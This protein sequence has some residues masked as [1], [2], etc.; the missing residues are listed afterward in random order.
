MYL[1]TLKPCLGDAVGW[2]KGGSTSALRRGA[3]GPTSGKR[4][5]NGSKTFQK[6]KIHKSQVGAAIQQKHLQSNQ[7]SMYFLPTWKMARF[8]GSSLGWHVRVKAPGSSPVGTGP[9]WLLEVHEVYDSSFT[10][11]TDGL[12]S[13]PN[14]SHRLS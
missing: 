1:D 4:A 3:K 8:I 2:A 10:G 9:N 7:S 6:R 14:R 11:T 13:F 12:Q 5:A